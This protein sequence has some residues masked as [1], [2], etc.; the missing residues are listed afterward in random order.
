MKSANEILNATYCGDI[1]TQTNNITNLKHEYREY[2]KIYHPDVCNI[3]N[4]SLVFQKLNDLYKQAEDCLSKGT[5]QSSKSIVIIDSRGYTHTIDNI[6]HMHNYELGVV[7]VC[8]DYLYI[9]TTDKKYYDNFIWKCNT[10][11]LLNGLSSPHKS[12]HFLELLLSKTCSTFENDGIYYIQIEK[13]FDYYSLKTVK[14]KIYPNGVP[15]RHITWIIS[16][17]MNIC[18]ILSRQNLSHN[19][20]TIESVYICPEYHLARV[21]T[22]WQYCVN[23]NEKM[24][25]TT[26]QVYQN[27]FLKTKQSKTGSTST[28]VNCV[29][30]IGK[31]LIGKDSDVPKPIMDWLNSVSS[32]DTHKDF[33]AWDKAITDAYGKRTFV[34]MNIT[35]DDIYKK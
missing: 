29:K 10:T 23:I 22:G 28:D 25:G 18:M 24:L 14:D 21:L 13:P 35:Y 7:Y 5:W 8:R 31:Q 9:T 2:A 19:G 32:G 12:N 1:F 6:I 16:K 33:T 11:K 4:A 3:S 26:Q 20:I 15:A 30:Y 17:L 34:E 27:M